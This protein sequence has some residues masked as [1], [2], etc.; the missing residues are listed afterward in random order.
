MTEPVTK[1]LLNTA[2]GV[3]GVT[4]D[5]ENGKCKAVAFDN[6]PTFVFALDNKVNVPGF[7][8][9]SVDVGAK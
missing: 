5:C 8:T 6:I 1:M 4:T 9:V 3:V 2:A 7:G